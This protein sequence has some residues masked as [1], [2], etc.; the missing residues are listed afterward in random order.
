MAEA[1]ESL[2]AANGE[3]DWT[4]LSSISDAAAEL[5]DALSYRARALLPDEAEWAHQVAMAE[6]R[7]AHA[8]LYWGT[9]HKVFPNAAQASSRYPSVVRN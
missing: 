1:S 8:V 5:F 4:K 3:R 2:A 6:R 7:Q 9:S